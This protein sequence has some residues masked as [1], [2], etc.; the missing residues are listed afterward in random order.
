MLTLH[1]AL[2]RIAES[3]ALNEGP[4]AS[5]SFEGA[6]LRVR[7]LLTQPLP[8]AGNTYAV[9]R[10]MRNWVILDTRT[11]ERVITVHPWDATTN[12]AALGTRSASAD[13]RAAHEFCA[14]IDNMTDEAARIGL[15]GPALTLSQL[16]VRLREHLGMPTQNARA[17]MDR[18][19]AEVQR[20]RS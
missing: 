14:R 4:D 20:L 1:E 6:V 5:C 12:V 2:H 13:I 3:S 10:V 19:D 11:N 8:C 7:D 16:S 15:L 17:V 18:L 9:K